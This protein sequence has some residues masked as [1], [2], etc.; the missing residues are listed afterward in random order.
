MTKLELNAIFYS[1]Q[2]YT[3]AY[4]LK[5]L[6]RELGVNLINAS[7]ISE[8][9]AYLNEYKI[10]I[11]FIDTSSAEC[12]KNIL[13]A[14]KSFEAGDNLK[15]I[16]L[17]NENKSDLKDCGLVDYI[18]PY[19]SLKENVKGIIQNIALNHDYNH[20]S[21]NYDLSEIN[22]FLTKYLISLGFAPKHIGFS[23]IKNAI[24]LSV[25]S[26]SILPSLSKQL[27]PKVAT[28]FKTQPQNV[29]RNIR[30]SIECAC[31]SNEI[32]DNDLKLLMQNGKVS[33]R[34]FLG[35]L[36]DKVSNIYSDK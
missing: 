32:L 20:S 24:E 36:L 3:L 27:Y 6:C 14:I 23:F 29:E 25:K 33:N 2:N 16:C 30:N 7:K 4:D 8:L 18:L 19:A 34:A 35:F 10:E 28:K 22:T 31:K 9:I 21:N 12:D 26:N 17:T 1:K 5:Q 11:V 15:T 13:T